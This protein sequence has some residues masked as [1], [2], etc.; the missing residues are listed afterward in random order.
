MKKFDDEA[1]QYQNSDNEATQF[2]DKVTD[3]GNSTD[4]TSDNEEAKDESADNEGAKEKSAKGGK[5]KSTAA[6]TGVGLLIGGLSTMLMGMTKADDAQ[7]SN[8]GKAELTHPEWVD[9]EIAV[10]TTVND[11]MSFSEAFAAAREEVGAGGCFEWHGN[12][13][14]TF[15]ADEWNNMTAEERAEWG[16]HFSWNS[17]DHTQSDVAQHSPAAQQA[18][19]HV[20]AN[21][22]DDIEIVAVNNNPGED[23]I[24]ANTTAGD[25]IVAVSHNPGDEVV[26][27][28]DEPQIEI[29]GVV[30]D[31][32]AGANIGAVT[33]DQQDVVFIDVDDNLT[34]DYMASDANHNNKLDPDEV[35]D[36]SDRNITVDDLGGFTH[37]GADPMAGNETPDIYN[38]GAYDA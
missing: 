26:A 20:V 5:W 14:G 25:D 15:T 24:D 35:I 3:N 1:T 38:G 10:A 32:V 34:F 28:V 36:I 4:T 31:D 12:L 30:H 6:G 7:E 33:I 16:D 22:D 8:D 2:E 23:T 29:L 17:I 21:A 9:D 18:D 37:P 19:A 27:V 11:D 13:Y